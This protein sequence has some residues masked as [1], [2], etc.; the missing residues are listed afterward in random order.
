[1]S[2][3]RSRETQNTRRLFGTTARLV[4]QGENKSF[5]GDVSDRVHSGTSGRTIRHQKTSLHRNIWSSSASSDHDVTLLL[6]VGR[7]KREQTAV[8]SKLMKRWPEIIQFIQKLPK[9][10][11]SAL[12]VHSRDKSPVEWKLVSQVCSPEEG[13]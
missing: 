13:S 11:Q 8:L 1:M 9:I 7:E 12:L 4:L 2:N 10:K 6:L 5:T 3:K